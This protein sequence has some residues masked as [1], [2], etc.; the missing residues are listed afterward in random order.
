MREVIIL[1]IV[2]PVYKVELYINKCLDS[3]IVT[4]E[5]MEKME[6]LIINDGTPDRSAELSRGYVKRF[7]GTFRQIDKENAGHGSVWNLGLKEAYGK[8]TRFL[9]S[10]DWLE[11]LDVLIKHLE[12]CD[13]DLVL[14][15]TQGH[16]V[17]QGL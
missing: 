3:L 7:P 12:N 14:T 16:G 17:W 1:T 11:N 13:A 5:L 9:D 4:P 10:D 2:I 15:P 6:V 8:Y